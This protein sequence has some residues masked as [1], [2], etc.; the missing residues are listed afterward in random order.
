MT[1]LDSAQ[2]IKVGSLLRADEFAN[3]A[4][5][6]AAVSVIDLKDY[7]KERAL[8][9]VSN[10]DAGGDT[11]ISVEHSDSS[12]T[13]F[14]AVTASIL[15]NPATGATDVF[16]NLN[17]AGTKTLA[18]DLRRCRRYLRIQVATA[19]GSATAVSAVLVGRYAETPA[20]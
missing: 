13:G 6:N 4:A 9:V 7:F 2:R 11:T 14:A 10:E 17:T 8:I 15:T 19:F 16:G 18:V 3:I 20:S 5:L 12:S 1:I